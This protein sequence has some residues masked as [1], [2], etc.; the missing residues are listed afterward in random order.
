MDKTDIIKIKRL[1]KKLSN[2]YE[3]SVEDVRKIVESP[4]HFTHKQLLSYNIKELKEKDFENLKKVFL[5]K[6]LGKLYISEKLVSKRE[7]LRE[8]INKVNNKKWNK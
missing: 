4:Y 5:Y 8:N 7:K 1:I 2:K 3:L 6:G